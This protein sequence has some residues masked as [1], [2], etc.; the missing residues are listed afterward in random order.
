MHS[1]KTDKNYE[2][3]INVFAAKRLKGLLN[4]DLGQLVEKDSGGLL[5][6]LSTDIEL[7]ANCLFVTSNAEKQGVSDEDF[8]K[9]LDGD[10]FAK[11]SDAF[12]EEL[13]D[14]FQS[15]RPALAQT[16]RKHLQVVA[17]MTAYSLTQLEA[18]GPVDQMAAKLLEE[19]QERLNE[20]L[21]PS[22]GIQSGNSQAS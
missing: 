16:I 11:A 17:K 13:V 2:I 9:S 20:L 6:R 18:G 5:A 1:F 7:M 4:V 19:Q 21:Q 14:F 10:G 3:S 15:S 22:S 8:A 12:W